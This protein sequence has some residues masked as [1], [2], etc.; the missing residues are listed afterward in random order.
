MEDGEFV[1]RAPAGDDVALPKATVYKFANEFAASMEFRLTME[2]R[3]LLA[4]CCTEFVQLLSSEANEVC[5]KESK[6]T[7]TPEH[8]LKAMKELGLSQFYDEVSDE[9]ERHKDSEKQSGRGRGNAWSKMGDNKISQEELRKQQE[10]LFRMARMDPLAASR[11]AQAAREREV[12][13]ED[14]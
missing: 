6:K 10:E 8:V 2:A 1:S 3:E 12:K 14:Q 11:A 4:E 13:R 9:Y 5:E 7:I